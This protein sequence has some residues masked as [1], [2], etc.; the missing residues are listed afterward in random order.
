MQ[1][2]PIF[3]RRTAVVSSASSA[4]SA[5]TGRSKAAA[6]ANESVVRKLRRVCIIGIVVLPPSQGS[7]LQLAFELVQK[8]PIRAVGDDLVRARL[9]QARLVQPQ[10]VKPHRVF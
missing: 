5:G 7:R 4:A 9:D 1:I 3:A 10:R 2:D 6:P 8:A